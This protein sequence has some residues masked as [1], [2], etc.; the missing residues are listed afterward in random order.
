MLRLNIFDPQSITR[1]PCP[2]PC[3]PR[4]NSSTS[5]TATK[6]SGGFTRRCGWCR[7]GSE[8]IPLAAAL[9]RVLAED[10]RSPVDVPSFDRSN[11][12]GYAI[13]AADTFGASESKPRTL[14][15]LPEAI[16]TAVVPRSHVAAGRRS[17]LPRAAWCRAAQ[18]RWSWSSTRIL[19]VKNCLCGGRSRRAR[20]S[21]SP[22]PTLRLANWCSMRGE[23]LTSRET[24]VLAAIGVGEV[25]AIRRPRVA[26]LSTG[27]EI[28]APGQPMQPGLV[29]D[30]NAR[31]VADAVR[32]LGGEPVELGIVR[33]DLAL[34]RGRLQSALASCD[35]VLL[36]GGTSKG[37]G[38]LSLSGRQ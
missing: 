27:D 28:I 12:D 6:P 10:V 14:A 17:K 33:D 23:V 21:R 38:D 4:T 34:L 16:A 30:S 8:L 3:L 26:I 15:L 35:L 19:T 36:S 1:L 9:G 7:C 31:I 2:A 24:G 18:T 29:Y 13:R 25:S 11:V 22:A 37:A 20:T 5:S 32:E